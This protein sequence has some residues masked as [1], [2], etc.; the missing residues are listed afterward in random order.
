[1]PAKDYASTRYSGLDQINAGNVRDLKVS[2]TF[3]TGVQR[4]QEA[5]PIVVDDTMYIATPYPNVLYALDLTKPAAAM[6]WK[7]EP[8]PVSAAQ[9][10]A[11]CDV[12][13][14]G[15]TYSDGRVFL[16]TLDGNTI[17]VDAQTGEELWKTPL[18]DINKGETITMAPLVAKDKVLVGNSGGELGVRGW[19]TALDAGSGEIRWRAYSTGPDSEV[20]IGPNFKPFYEQ[21]RGKDLGVTSWPPEAWRIG[22][23][24]VWGWISYDP[25]LEL[26]YYGTANPGPWN[27]EQRPGDNKWTAGIFARQPDT[28]EA[29]WF[30]Q[31]SPHDIFDHDGVNEQILVDLSEGGNATRHLLLRAE[32]NGYVYVLDRTTGEVLSAD[33]FVHITTSRGVDLATGKLIPVEESKPVLGHVKR[34]LCPA[35]PGGKDWNPSAFSPRTRLL[36]IPHNNLC[37]D[38]E[39]LEANYIAGTPFLG[40]TVRMYAG[41]GGNRGAFTAWNP[42]SRAPAW[43]VE[44]KYPVWSGA[45]VTAGDIVFYGTM[46]GFLKALDAKTGQLLWQFKTGSGIVGQPVVYRGADGKQYVAIL[47]GIGGWAGAIVAGGLDPRD[48]SAALGFVNAMKDLPKDTAAGGTL[49]VFSLP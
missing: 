48:G 33:P 23:G 47:S 44:E 15:A 2:W 42:M 17:A 27:H 34:D 18:A 16:N 1:M 39:S 14:R 5:A 40:A 11:C 31:W 19:L 26:L 37:M 36:Y 7:Y 24:T 29:L 4:G 21:D 8:K 32:R 43:K 49:Y 38:F 6:K 45:V 35:A 10:V 12:V 3:S 46:E 25:Q 30:Y 13:N 22:G 9:G 41:P 20:L 28:G